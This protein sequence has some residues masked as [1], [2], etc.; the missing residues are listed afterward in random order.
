MRYRIEYSNN[1]R[2][3]VVNSRRELLVRL[4]QVAAGIV[5]DVRKIYKSGVSDSVY[6][7]YKNFIK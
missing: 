1:Q 4:N 7:S 5:L 3:E 6:D 2:C